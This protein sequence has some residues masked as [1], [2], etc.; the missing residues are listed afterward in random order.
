MREA[1][2]VIVNYDD[3]ANKP[4]IGDIMWAL[5]DAI[6]PKAWDI[7]ATTLTSSMLERHELPAEQETP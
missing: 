6:L 4:V 1:F 3:P 5:H 7:H 2:I